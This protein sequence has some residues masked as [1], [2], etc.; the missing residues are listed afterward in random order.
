MASLSAIETVYR[1]RFEAFLRV[2]AA[3]AGDEQRGRDVV[4][5]AFVR[6]V[7][8]RRRLRHE[9]RL[10]PWLWRIVVNEARRRRRDERRLTTVELAAEPAAASP[11]GHDEHRALRAAITALP[12]RQRLVLFLRYFADLDYEAIAET[13]AIAP[14][15]V[16]ATLHAAH[17]KLRH[18]LQEVRDDVPT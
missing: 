2:A 17:A 5:E 7:R 18:Q 14:G 8:H 13:L 9:D 12:E 1:G 10:E 15:T 11:N 6:A 3:V 4:H 16:A